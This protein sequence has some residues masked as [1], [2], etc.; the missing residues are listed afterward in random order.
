[1][2]EKLKISLRNSLTFSTALNP[3]HRRGTG[4][5]SPK[6]P[7]Q[8]TTSLQLPAP[9]LPLPDRKK[10]PKQ[11]SKRDPQIFYTTPKKKINKDR[12]TVYA[13]YFT[14]RKQGVFPVTLQGRT[15][16]P[17]CRP[18]LGS[19]QRLRAQI[20]GTGLCVD[21]LATGL[22]LGARVYK[23]I[24][25]SRR[26]VSFYTLRFYLSSLCAEY[27]HTQWQTL[28]LTNKKKVKSETAATTTIL[29]LSEAHRSQTD[30]PFHS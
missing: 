23:T 10:N 1:M 16:C 29:G 9:R 19:R 4:A 22:T 25:S 5:T 28:L 7:A 12:S 15:N 30:A 14:A 3:T 13:P 18:L 8:F 6:Q 11:P 21:G 17:R 24:S 2:Q 26:A 20:P 27:T